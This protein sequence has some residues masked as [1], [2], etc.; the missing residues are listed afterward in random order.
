MNPKQPLS[1]EDLKIISD[2]DTEKNKID[3][4]IEYGEKKIKQISR[5]I[6]ENDVKLESMESHSDYEYNDLLREYTEAEK[7]HKMD[8]KLFVDLLDKYKFMIR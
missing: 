3:L 7:E 5:R 8:L 4:I 6:S 1:S 2:T